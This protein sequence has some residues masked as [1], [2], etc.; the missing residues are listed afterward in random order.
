MYVYVDALCAYVHT[1]L[2]ANSG[3]AYFQMPF[4]LFSYSIGVQHP[5]FITV[6]LGRRWSTRGT[7][8]KSGNI[9]AFQDQMQKTAG[10]Q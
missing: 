6:E 1:F 3:A 5:Q 4:G 2:Q 10:T 8:G 7:S 9:L